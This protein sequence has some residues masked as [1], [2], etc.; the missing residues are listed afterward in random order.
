MDSG[1]G[2]TNRTAG[3]AV[4]SKAFNF[5]AANHDGVPVCWPL[6]RTVDWMLGTVLG[7][8]LEVSSWQSLECFERELYAV[9]NSSGV[10][11]G[12]FFLI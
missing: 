3:L 2:L 7:F 4:K 11:F 6:N 9:P 10:F 12:V 8:D 5:G 1:P